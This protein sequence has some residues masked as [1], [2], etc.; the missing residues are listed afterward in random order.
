MFRGHKVSNKIL[1]LTFLDLVLNLLTQVFYKSFV[2]WLGNHVYKGLALFQ[3]VVALKL[4]TSKIPIDKFRYSAEN[5]LILKNNQKHETSLI[6]CSLIC[7]FI[8]IWQRVCETSG[9]SYT[10]T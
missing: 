5:C 6:A 4:N 2:T 8:M 3:E 10:K 9:P 7:S 1:T